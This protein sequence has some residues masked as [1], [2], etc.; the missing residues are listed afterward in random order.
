MELINCSQTKPFPTDKLIE[1]DQVNK[2]CGQYKIINFDTLQFKYVKDI[3][4][5][6]VF[7]FTESDIPNVLNW[8]RDEQAYA[9][10]HCE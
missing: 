6:P 9:K 1:Y 7:G 5:P 8:I 4:C 2:V 10:S 3:P